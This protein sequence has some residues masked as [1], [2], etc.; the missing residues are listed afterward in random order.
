M[1]IVTRSR[2]IKRGKMLNVLRENSRNLDSV[3]G[4]STSSTSR[5]YTDFSETIRMVAA[6]LGECFG[7]TQVALK[8]EQTFSNL[9]HVDMSPDDVAWQKMLAARPA[10]RE[11]VDVQVSKGDLW[12][13]PAAEEL[14]RMDELD[15]ID[16]TQTEEGDEPE[17]DADPAPAASDSDDDIS[18]VK[19]KAKRAKMQVEY[20]LDKR[21]PMRGESEDEYSQRCMFL[22][23]RGQDD[24][25][26]L[27]QLRRSSASTQ[28][29][30]MDYSLGTSARKFFE[31]LKGGTSE[32]KPTSIVDHKDGGEKHGRLYLVEWHYV[33]YGPNKRDWKTLDWV[34]KYPDLLDDYNKVF[35][36]CH[37]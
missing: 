13:A 16:L 6:H 22:V 5:S 15:I 19:F 3:Y 35:F 37:T 4:M 2:L 33:G 18:L 11:Y 7:T 8:R 12:V 30:V 17:D 9:A 21:R 27:Q 34:G 28:E 32:D 29:G 25:A 24:Q 20:W 26:R 10:L 23:S 1:P 31:E 36:A 14:T